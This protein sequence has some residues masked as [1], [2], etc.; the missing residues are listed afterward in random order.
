LSTGPCREVLE[1]A[2]EALL[3]FALP[4]ACF[5]CG[6]PL[7][8][9]QHLGAC[10]RC[11]TALRPLEGLLCPSCSLP[12]ASRTDL[13]GPARG[14]CAAC[15]RRRF[16][17]EAARAAV[18]YDRLAGRFLRR[19][20]LSRRRELLDPLG[21]LLVRTLETSGFA[22]GSEL[23]VP[24]PARIGTRL[25]RGFNPALDLARAVSRRLAVP[26]A[27]GALRAR[28]GVPAAKR[29]PAAVRR[30]RAG[31]AFAARRA[32]D[33]RDVLL[34]DDVMTTGATADGCAR[35]LLAAGARRVRVA[36]WAR[37]P[38]RVDRV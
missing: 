14:R 1:R 38:P 28:L 29:S 20:K 33:A 7:G 13:L 18:I 22:E 15:V 31:R 8:R 36:V 26:L 34:V 19:A 5:G 37:T 3:G 23:V 2:T 25:A 6:R 30:S 27:P 10:P 4:S 9:R 11:W 35:A 32:L 16:G 24:V 21:E 17:F 12:A